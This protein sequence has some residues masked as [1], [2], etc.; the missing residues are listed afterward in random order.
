MSPAETAQPIEMPSG[1]RIRVSSR[2]HVLDGGGHLPM[3]VGSFEGRE[4]RPTAKY[5]DTVV[6]CAKT[7]QLMMT[8]FG[9]WAQTGPRNVSDDILP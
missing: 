9:L 6:I 2:K 1:L 3:G 7:A 8:P 5:R 4:G